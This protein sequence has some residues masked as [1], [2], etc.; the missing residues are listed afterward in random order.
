MRRL[1]YFFTVT[2]RKAIPVN[3][4]AH[5]DLI[6]TLIVCAVI[7]LFISIIALSAINSGNQPPL[8]PEQQQDRWENDPRW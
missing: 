6:E 3:S 2:K 7:T 4:E 8:T 1:L 5:I